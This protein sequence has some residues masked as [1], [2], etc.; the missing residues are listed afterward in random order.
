MRSVSYTSSLSS[1]LH[2]RGWSQTWCQ[3]RQF[4][5]L[6]PLRG[7]TQVGM[8]HHPNLWNDLADQLSM[9]ENRTSELS[10]TTIPTALVTALILAAAM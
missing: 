5:D 3:N 1:S 6:F 8:I 10:E 4:A 7:T 2:D 9:A